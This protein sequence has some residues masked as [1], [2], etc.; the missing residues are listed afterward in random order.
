MAALG[1]KSTTTSTTTEDQFKLPDL[2]SSEVKEQTS[3]QEQ[4]LLKPLPKPVSKPRK[5]FCTHFSKEQIKLGATLQKEQQKQRAED[6]LQQQGEI[7]LMQEEMD[8]MMRKEQAKQ[9]QAKRYTRRTKEKE[10]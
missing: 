6:A 8:E 5:Y 3:C 4:E 10:E 1:G 2:V 7:E 9:E